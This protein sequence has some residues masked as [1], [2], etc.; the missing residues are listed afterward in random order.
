MTRWSLIAGRLP[1]RTANDVKNYWNTH[2]LKKPAVTPNHQVA[3]DTN[4]TAMKTTI[5]RPRPWTFS[6]NLNW[7]KGTHT[8]VVSH[9]NIVPSPENRN[10]ASPAVTDD[11][12]RWWD[13]LVVDKGLGQGVAFSLD[14]SEES[15]T[16]ELWTHEM[17]SI[18]TI[19]GER[20][21]QE[22]HGGFS[23]Y[24]MD[25]DIWELLSSDQLLV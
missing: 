11:S 17:L 20:F 7:L 6:K 24:S 10:K 4:Q 16:N 12:M 8:N 14:G 13:D 3:K 15:R 25:M 21:V 1:G 22:G 5:I 23:D 19:G 2:L 18:G 9:N